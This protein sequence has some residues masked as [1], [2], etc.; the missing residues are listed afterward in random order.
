MDLIIFHPTKGFWADSKGWTN[1]LNA[2][3]L[4]SGKVIG[5]SAAVEGGATYVDPKE[6]EHVASDELVGRLVRHHNALWSGQQMARVASTVLGDEVTYLGDSLWSI[7]G[8]DIDSDELQE[9][10]RKAAGGLQVKEL[11]RLYES[12][13]GNEVWPD[14]RDGFYHYQAATLAG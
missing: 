8:C 14:G 9:R 11:G 6:Y 5:D 13:T 7:E 12:V 1:E 10:I 2:A 4:I 3:T